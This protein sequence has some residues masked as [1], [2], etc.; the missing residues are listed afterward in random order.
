[1]ATILRD[2][3]ESDIDFIAWVMLAASRSHLDRG[4]WEYMNDQGE[5]ETLAFL[6]HVGTTETVHLFHHSRFVIAEVDGVP[7]AAMCAYDSATQG[8][9]AYGR[10]FPAAAAASGVVMD[11]EFGRRMG[12][13]MSGLVHDPVGPDGPRWVVE[14]VATAPAFRRQGLVNLLLE[15]LFERGRANGFDTAQIGVFL[16]NEPA[17]AAYIKAGFDV[18]AEQRSQGWSDE[19]G[20]PGT[21]LLLKTL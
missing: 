6:R 19:I 14:N 3:T 21:E 11:E 4:V 18:V 15:E 2:A 13:M 12:V 9:D 1:M 16:G 20:C 7:G 10:E 5:E 8:F 17:R